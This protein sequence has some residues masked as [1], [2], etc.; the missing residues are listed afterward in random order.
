MRNPRHVQGEGSKAAAPGPTSTGLF[1]T[2]DDSTNKQVLPHNS[3]CPLATLQVE[4][5]GDCFMA[6]AGCPE[7][8]SPEDA[9]RRAASMALDMISFAEVRMRPAAVFEG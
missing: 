3:C 8:C 2:G 1:S 9:A 4:T 6:V 7:R 5:I